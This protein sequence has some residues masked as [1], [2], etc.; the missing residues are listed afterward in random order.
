MNDAFEQKVKMVCGWDSLEQLPVLLQDE[1][2][3]KPLVVCDQV[4]RKIGLLGRVEKLLADA[5]LES[6]ERLT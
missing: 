6:M 3:R 5:G 2:Y 4:A 1:E